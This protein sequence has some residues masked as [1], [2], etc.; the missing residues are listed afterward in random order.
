MT[1]PQSIT[2]AE[3]S[4]SR[5]LVTGQSFDISHEFV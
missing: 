4:M 2:D 5:E 3:V 1:Y